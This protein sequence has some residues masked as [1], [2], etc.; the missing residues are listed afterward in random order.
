[1]TGAEVRRVLRQI[2]ESGNATP[3][4][5]KAYVHCDADAAFGGAADVVAFVH[6]S[7]CVFELAACCGNLGRSLPFQ[8][9]P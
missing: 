2:E 6:V 1:M 3:Q 9:T 8:A 5:A 7:V 4:I